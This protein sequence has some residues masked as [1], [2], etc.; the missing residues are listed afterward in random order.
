VIPE[1]A[2]SIA[3]RM[4]LIADMT[5]VTAASMGGMSVPPIIVWSCGVVVGVVGGGCVDGGLVDGGCVDGGLV[6]GGWVGGGLVDGGWVDGGLVDG[7]CVDGVLVDG[8]CV[9]GGFPEP[10]VT[11]IVPVMY[12]WNRQWMPKDPALSKVQENLSPG[13]RSWEKRPSSLV[14]LWT[15]PSVSSL[16]HTTVD[17]TGIVSVA[18]L[19]LKFLIET[20]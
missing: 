12:V 17:P 20:V 1:R 6:D 2:A 3:M 18:G 16:L 8:G 14:T 10:L 5:A 11:V 19:K 15:V 9:D 13:L 7:G 4:L